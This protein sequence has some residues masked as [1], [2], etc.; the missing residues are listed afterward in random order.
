V[1]VTRDVAVGQAVLRVLDTG[2]GVD[3]TMLDRMFK[4]FAQADRTLA[5]SLG[6]LGLGLALVKGLVDL[7]GGE[8]S[9]H[10]E[11][12]NRGAEFVVRLPLVQGGGTT[13]SA[14]DSPA[15]RKTARRVVLI[16]DNVDA[17]DAL[18]SLLELDGHVVEVAHDGADGIALARRSHPDI[19]LCDLGLPGVNGYDV[20][21]DLANDVTLRSTRLV[22]LSGYATPEDVAQAR[23]SGFDEHLAKP[24]ALERL[25]HVLDSDAS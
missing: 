4:P 22:A 19:V 12:V 2:A 18:R 20:A 21:R 14:A 16:E 10:S 15:P 11:G 7:H 17:A 24:V 6:G 25:R 13:T 8:V 9:V 3:P 23:A 5:R 1:S